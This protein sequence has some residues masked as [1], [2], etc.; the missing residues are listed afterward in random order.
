[1]GI[2]VGQIFT[3]LGAIAGAIS[4]G[5]IVI[6]FCR[7]MILNLVKEPLDQIQAQDVK[8]CNE[9][10]KSL[11]ELRDQVEKTNE[12]IANVNMNYIKSFLV[13]ILSSAQRGEELTEI[14]RLRFHEE[15][16]Y[17][18]THDGNSY[19]AE[20]YERLHVDGKI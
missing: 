2:T 20:W 15:Y 18:R 14:E 12:S 13:S 5:G 3:V 19:I 4:A 9:V 6:A 1:M 16:T 10:K 8:S 11:G 17:Y 7:K